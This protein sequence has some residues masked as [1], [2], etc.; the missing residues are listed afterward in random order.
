MSTSRAVRK[1]MRDWILADEGDRW[2]VKLDVR[3]LG[4]HLDTTFRGWSAT[5]ACGVRLV[6]SRLV[7]IFVLPLDFHGR[8]QVIRSMFVPGALHG[9]E[10]S[11]LA[12]SSLLKLRSSIRR[13]I[14]SR[15]PPLANGGAVQSLLDG[16]QGCDLAYCVV[17]FRYRFRMIRRYV[18]YRPSEIGSIY[19]LLDM[20]REGVQGMVLSTFWLL[21][22][23]VLGS[24]GPARAWL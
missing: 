15:R 3:D 9:I 5:L 2:T 11:L 18:A 4:V 6:I 16:P 13:V 14:W 20:V 10:A 21:V 12:M 7:L 8:L 22:P 23:L 17:R 1:D 19:R 24:D